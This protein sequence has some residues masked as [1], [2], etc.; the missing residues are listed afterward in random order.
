MVPRARHNKIVMGKMELPPDRRPVPVEP[1]TVEYPGENRRLRAN[2]IDVSFAV[3][4]TQ[5]GLPIQGYIEAINLSWS[6]MLLATNFPLNVGD[7][8]VLEFTLPGKEASLTAHA[9]VIHKR[10]EERPEEATAIGVAFEELDPN[11]QRM[12]SGYVLEKLPTD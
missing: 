12:L 5:R 9:R 4:A 6:G 10:V 8:L 7:R 3:V 2:R 11:V 1:H